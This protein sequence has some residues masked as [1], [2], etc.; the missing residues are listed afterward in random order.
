[1]IDHPYIISKKGTEGPLNLGV[2][3]SAYLYAGD[4]FH[5][6]PIAASW[7]KNNKPIIY[8]SP[9]SINEINPYPTP[10]MEYMVVIKYGPWNGARSNAVLVNDEGE[11]IFTLDLPKRLA[12]EEWAP[13]N[14]GLE[15]FRWCSWCKDPDM[16]EFVAAIGETDWVEFRYWNYKTRQW[17]E[18]KYTLARL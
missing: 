15:Y 14:C 17:D 12:K 3:A 1:M 9:G 13:K 16:M 11:E 18:E 6:G 2:G 8:R 4:A 10:D 5:D 7:T